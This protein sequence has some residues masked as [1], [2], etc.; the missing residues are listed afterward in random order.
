MQ[1]MKEANLILW[2][3]E[4]MDEEKYGLADSW[5]IKT[6]QH[7]GVISKIV[8]DKSKSQQMHPNEARSNWLI[9]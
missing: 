8:L 7:A 2:K 4:V 1:L 5:L 6:D 3:W 9:S